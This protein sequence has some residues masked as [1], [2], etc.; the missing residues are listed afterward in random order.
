MKGTEGELVGGLLP[1]EQVKG[2]VV[3]AG[4]AVEEE[5]KNDEKRGKGNQQKGQPVTRHVNEGSVCG[6]GPAKSR[7]G[8]GGGAAMWE[9]SRG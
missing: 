8:G 7:S 1:A 3:A 4:G 5:G 2:E 6:R 9:G